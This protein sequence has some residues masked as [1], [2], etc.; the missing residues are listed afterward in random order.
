M[1]RKINKE[2]SGQKMRMRRDRDEEVV[3]RKRLRCLDGV[4]DID[5]NDCEMAQKFVTEHGKIMPARMTGANARQQRQVK[6]AVRRARVM[7]LLE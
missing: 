2:R 7:G 4:V 6:R 5:P 3:E 1:A